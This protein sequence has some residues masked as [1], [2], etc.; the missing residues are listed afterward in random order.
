MPPS[1]YLFALL[2]NLCITSGIFI[3]HTIH[4]HMHIHWCIYLYIQS[5]VYFNKHFWLCLRKSFSLRILLL[6]RLII[7]G[8]FFFLFFCIVVLCVC[9]FFF[10]SFALYPVLTSFSILLRFIERTYNMHSWI[11]V[12]SVFTQNPRHILCSIWY[13]LVD[14]MSK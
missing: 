6:L 11:G 1:L 14:W 12:Y 9:N 10:L 2:Q 13:L 4:T 5:V 7:L 8:S 3:P